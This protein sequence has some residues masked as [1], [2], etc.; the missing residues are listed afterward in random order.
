VHRLRFKIGPLREKE[1][2]VKVRI[3]MRQ[4]KCATL[5]VHVLETQRSIADYFRI[6]G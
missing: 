3:Q 6:Y 2:P 5:V 4:N 1:Q